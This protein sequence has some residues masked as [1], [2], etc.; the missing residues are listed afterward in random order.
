MMGV[1]TVS[2]FWRPS[3][4]STANAANAANAAPWCLTL[5][6]REGGGGEEV[7]IAANRSHRRVKAAAQAYARRQSGVRVIVE[8]W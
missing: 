5:G 6:G 7:R 4:A 8:A 1:V 3:R 2:Q